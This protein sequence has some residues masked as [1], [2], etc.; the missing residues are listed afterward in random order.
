MAFKWL[1]GNGDF[2]DLAHH[3]W[4]DVSDDGDTLQRIEITQHR[5]HSFDLAPLENL[6][7]EDGLM[8]VAIDERFGNFKRMELMQAAMLQGFKLTSC[9]HPSASIARDV[10]LSPNVYIGANSVV[11]HGCRIDFNTVI[12]AGVN[13]GPR[14]R[15]QSSCWIDAGVQIGQSVE[16]GANSIVRMGASVANGVRIGKFCD[17][18]WPRRYSEDIKNKT[19]FDLRYDEPIHVYEP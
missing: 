9:I 13:I 16:I 2:L 19:V 17:L 8:F 5:D 7:P 10:A 18:G 6:N 11:G 3:A 4:Q 12:H 14:T 15:L 1:I